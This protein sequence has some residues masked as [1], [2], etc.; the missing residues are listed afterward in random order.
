MRIFIVKISCLIYTK[1]I[2]VRRTRHA[3]HWEKRRE[4]IRDIRAS[5]TI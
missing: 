5:G 2:Q 1:T 3:G 4:G